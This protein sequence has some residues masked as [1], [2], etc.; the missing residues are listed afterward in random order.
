[1][2]K[3]SELMMQTAELFAQQSYARRKKVGA[4]L[5]KDGRILA[6]GYNGTVS[7]Q[8]NFCEEYS[9]HHG[10]DIKD[11]DEIVNCPSCNNGISQHP[12]ERT[13]RDDTCGHCKGSG[14]VVIHNKT[15][16]FTLHAEQNVITFC[17]KMGIPT[18]GCTMHITLSPCKDCAKL[19]VQ[20]G[21]K[22]VFYKELY[23]PDGIEFLRDC[24]VLATKI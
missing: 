12:V 14:Q 4:V 22:R 8:L 15:N 23:Q 9:A 17:A 18:A 3:Y 11:D 2:E 21:I 16:Q 10:Q 7:G 5:S 1:M 20:S 6:T 13:V 24:G 19:I